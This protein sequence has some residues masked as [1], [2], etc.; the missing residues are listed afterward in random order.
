MSQIKPLQ[1][2]H[3]MLN[4]DRLGSGMDSPFGLI[5]PQGGLTGGPLTYLTHD[6]Q[7]GQPGPIVREGGPTS[8]LLHVEIP[9]DG[10]FKADDLCVSVDANPL[11]MTGRREANEDTDSVRNSASVHSFLYGAGDGRSIIDGMCWQHAIKSIAIIIPSRLVGQDLVVVLTG[12][13]KKDESQL[14][15]LEGSSRYLG[16]TSVMFQAVCPSTE[17]N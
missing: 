11:V 13:G 17:C 6:L 14:V 12:A 5:V 8:R 2:A 15:Q 16:L 1:Q 9:V 10:D 7:L 4:D 3:S